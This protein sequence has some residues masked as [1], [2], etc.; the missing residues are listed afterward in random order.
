[1][2]YVTSI[3]FPYLIH[4]R[5]RISFYCH[6]HKYWSRKVNSYKD[7]CIKFWKEKLLS[8]MDSLNSIFFMVER[9]KW[10][11]FPHLEENFSQFFSWLIFSG[12]YYDSSHYELIFD[13]IE[14]SGVHSELTQILKRSR[15]FSHWSGL[16]W[17][18]IGSF[19]LQT[20]ILRYS[21]V[22]VYRIH[23]SLWHG[24]LSM[25]I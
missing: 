5:S 18:L 9:L 24:Y 14:G 20:Q 8:Q 12:I 4:I 10:I 23:T 1:M 7:I 25:V 2:L 17:L 19:G 13:S 11:L 15:E 21:I 22:L 6:I 16:I 3:F